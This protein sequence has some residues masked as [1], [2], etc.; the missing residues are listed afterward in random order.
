MIE[1]NLDKENEI[2]RK[3][4]SL[5]HSEWMTFFF[6]PFFNRQPFGQDDELSLTELERFKKY[7]FEKKY[8]EAINTKRQGLRFWF[9]VIVL[10]A[11][12]FAFYDKIFS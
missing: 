5:T 10:V 8:T 11:V 2:K 3:N 12:A 1:K 7:G 4:A 6:L 9:I